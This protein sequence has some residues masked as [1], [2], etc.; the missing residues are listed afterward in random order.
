MSPKQFFIIVFK[1]SE[2]EFKSRWVIG[3]ALKENYEEIMELYNELSK[4]NQCQICQ[5]IYG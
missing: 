2:D 4:D 3:S 1:D 5:T